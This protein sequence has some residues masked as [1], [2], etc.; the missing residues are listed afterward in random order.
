M[1]ITINGRD[2]NLPAS[3]SAVTL[4]Q[5]IEFDKAHGKGLREQ[6]K[7]IEEM[8]EGIVKEMEFTDYHFQLA[9]KSL[10][11]FAGIPLDVVYNTAIED[12]FI[13]Y[14]NT[15]KGY[16]EDVDFAAKEFDLKNEF[17]WNNE[18]WV[19]AA[20]EL[21][22]D[23][24]M[25]FGEFLDAKQWV[26]NLYELSQEKYE[27]LLMLC[28]IYFRKKDEPYTKGLSIEEGDR[29]RLMKTLPLEFALHVGFFLNASMASYIQICLSSTPQEGKAV[30]QN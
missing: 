2:Y 29:Y 16:A 1:R 3:L 23:S 24:K 8:K 17:Q 11:F 12:V 26:K 10:S 18:T 27:A 28:C 14:H 21:K 25:T 20:P 6:L 7:K 30:D 9:C 13:M 4:G 15:M 5:R 22:H 19:V